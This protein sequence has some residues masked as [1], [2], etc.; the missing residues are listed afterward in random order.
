MVVFV[1]VGTPSVLAT[2]ANSPNFEAS[3]AEFGAGAALESC[4]GQYCAQATIG[5]IGGDD[6]SSQ[7][8][9]A[10][11]SASD[12]DEEPLLEIMIEPGEADLG[13]LD[14]NRTATRT[15]LL[16]VNS[17]R[18]GGYIV[19]VTGAP[20]SF[21]GYSLTTPIEPIASIQGSEQ[22]GINVTANTTPTIGADPVLLPDE[23]ATPGVVLPKYGT[24]NTFSYINGDVVARTNME[25]SKIRYTISMIVNVAGSTPAGHYSG[26]FSAFVT[27]DF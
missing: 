11:F 4:S 6:T 14:T 21:N 1:M 2:T 9:T 8:F 10:S 19:Q 15:M 17:H 25:S 24:P 20:P 18:A 27:P 7:N 16:H 12:E 3:E 26:D 13:K 22:F 23:S 5:G